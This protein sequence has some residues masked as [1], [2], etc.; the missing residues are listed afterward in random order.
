VFGTVEIAGCFPAA[1]L[2]NE[3]G[4][5][6]GHH[7]QCTA[8]DTRG[9]P[10]DAVPAARQLLAT[11]SNLVGVI[12]P[13]AD[14]ASATVPSFERA[15]V[16]MFV[17]TGQSA[18]DHSRFQYVWRLT[19]ADDL[20]G[21]AMAAWAH[22]RGYTRA[23]AVF[24]NDIS[25]QGSVA[26]LVA[27][28]RKLGITITTNLKVLPAQTSYRSEILSL[29]STHP[30]VIFDEMDPQ[31][32]ATFFS[33]LKTL[34]G[35]MLPAIGADPTLTPDWFKAVAKAIGTKTV[36]RYVTAENPSADFSGPT[37]QTYNT[38]LL[39]SKSQV[40]NPAQY[41]T[42]SYTEHIYDALNIMALAM[43]KAGSTIPAHYNSEV[44]SVTAPRPGAVVVHDFAAGKRAL[45]AGK[46]IQYVGPG[47]AVLFNQWHNSP[48]SFAIEAWNASGG[49]V[50]VG[51]LSPAEIAAA[52]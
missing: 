2:I 21:Y 12:G 29:L 43:L 19:P 1:R 38:A 5:V 3:A 4:G 42:Q 25:A 24:G 17:T 30:Q 11:A 45:A 6:L 44:T 14:E 22:K 33:E 40:P 26:T 39:K 9:D 36:V 47:G 37:W 41:S 23:A 35:H 32:S 27:A 10:A 8:V 50:T 15:H 34:N 7:V 51:A 16:T 46:E 13:S 31:T 48:G 49:N 18:F 52:R 20:A 28:A